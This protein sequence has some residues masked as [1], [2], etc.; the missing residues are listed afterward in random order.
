LVDIVDAFHKVENERQLIELTVEAIALWHDA[1]VR[2]YREDLSGSFVLEVWL[3]GVDISKAPR[4]LAGNLVWERDEVF[5]LDS[6]RDL[7]NIAWDVRSAET[8]FVPITV[9]DTTPWLI[10]VSAANASGLDDTLQFFRRFNGLL[11]S[12]LEREAEDSLQRRVVDR[13]RMA[14]AS[15]DATLQLGLE[16]S[17]VGIEASAAKLEVF[18]DGNRSAALSSAWGSYAESADEQPDVNSPH[19]IRLRSAIGGN[20]MAV[21]TFQKAP[22]VF[23]ARDVRL[24]RSAVTVFANWLSGT[25]RNLTEEPLGVRSG[26]PTDFLGRLRRDV[27]R[28]RRANKGGAL[29]VIRLR[30]ADP[31]GVE[32]DEVAHLLESHVRDSDTVGVVSNAAAALLPTL[33]TTM[34]GVIG[35][36]LLRAAAEHRIDVRVS[37]LPVV[38]SSETPDALVRRALSLTQNNDLL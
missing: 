6:V 2:A 15:F 24:V 28:T 5:R 35:D 23:S 14:D 7:E 10:T 36:R 19:Q 9:G 11:L 13:L 4:E 34:T 22:G 16:A 29:A 1:D 26:Q 30:A 25:L 27:E 32:L 17:A 8:L 37:V 21:F 33:P 12:S 38:V 20:A 18:Y 31:H 3:P